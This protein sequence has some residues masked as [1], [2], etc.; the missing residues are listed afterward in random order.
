M[1]TTFFKRKDGKTAAKYPRCQNSCGST[2][3]FP[4]VLP[5]K[6]TV[7]IENQPFLLYIMRISKKNRR[8]K[9]VNTLYLP[10]TLAA[11]GAAAAWL[12]GRWPKAATSCGLLSVTAGMIFGIV[13]MILRTK[14]GIPLTAS[15]IFALPVMILTLAAAIHSVGYLKGHP[16]HS[17]SAETGS[18]F[19]SNTVYRV[20]Y[21]FCIC[22]DKLSYLSRRTPRHIKLP[23]RI[24]EIR[25]TVPYD[26]VK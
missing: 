19:F 23:N 2:Q 1:E 4:A 10:S 26:C 7:A 16:Y 5:Q 13:D 17:F 8:N 15:D 25:K 12:S 21:R 3:I 24:L 22:A 14:N 6:T 9:K 20:C 18:Q 11:A